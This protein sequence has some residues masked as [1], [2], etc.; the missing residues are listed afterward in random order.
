MEAVSFDDTLG[1]IRKVVEGGLSED[2]VIPVIADLERGTRG[3]SDRS[4]RHE[5][6]DCGPESEPVATPLLKGS[7]ERIKE[8]AT[9]PNLWDP[10]DIGHHFTDKTLRELKIG[11]DG[12][13]L[14]AEEDR[15]KRMLEMHG[16]AFAFSPGEIGCVDRTV[17]EPMV[18]LTVSHV[19]WSLKPIQVVRAH[20]PMLMELLKQKVE[21]GI[22][23][24]SSAP[25]SN[26]WFTVTKKNGTL[27]FI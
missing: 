23:E 21:L 27:R 6:Q 11:G 25:Y 20:M 26:R 14:P 19:P 7:L 10:A 2:R 12:F 16:K 17:V 22:L 3:A 1:E 5:I 8:V 24:L 15:F 4:G 13:L 9:D 18:I